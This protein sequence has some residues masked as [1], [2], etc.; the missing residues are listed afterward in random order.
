M[1]KRYTFRKIHVVTCDNKIFAENVTGSNIYLHR[2]IAESV[3]QQW[4]RTAMADAGKMWNKGQP[5]RKYA[6]HSFYLVHE[7]LFEEILKEF[8]KD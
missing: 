2:E 5:V 7:S 8:C 6:A 1:G 3:A 4:Q